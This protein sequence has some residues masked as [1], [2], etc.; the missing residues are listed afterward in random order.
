MKTTK[1]FLAQSLLSPEL[2]ELNTER[3]ICFLRWK[4]RI[5]W[6]S[7]KNNCM[8]YLI[9]TESSHQ[10]SKRL[11]H[12]FVHLVCISLNLGENEIGFWA[13]SCKKAKK[14]IFV[15]LS[16]R[17]KK[18]KI[19]RPLSQV[20]KIIIDKI[21]AA[22]FLLLFSP[23]ILMI[24]FLIK[25]LSKDLLLS[26]EWRIGKRGK[27]FQ[28]VQCPKSEKIEIQYYYHKNP[29]GNTQ[30]NKK[31]ILDLWIQK[32]SLDKFFQLI[33][34]LKG[35]MSIVGPRALTFNEAIQMNTK[36]KTNFSVLPGII[37]PSSVAN[38]LSLVDK[39]QI[40]HFEFE[41]LSNWSLMKDII[42]FLKCVKYCMF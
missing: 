13:D 11:E 8:N 4:Y 21:I 34:V 32:S 3:N 39:D 24:I 25:F 1:K 26:K 14:P 29:N 38:C 10:L 37:G 18:I 12:S 7:D 36:Y 31:N 30:E 28:V 9:T 42:I 22:G 19:N 35:E 6:V 17:Q 20:F 41:Y 33:N 23:F 5:L 16:S 27:L 15:R 40:S 2:K